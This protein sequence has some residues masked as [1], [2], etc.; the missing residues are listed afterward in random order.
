[1]TQEIRSRVSSSCYLIDF[2]GNLWTFGNNE[3]GQLGHGDD[4][5]NINTPKIINTLI[6]IQQISYGC[7]G[8]HFFAKN[9]QN[10]IFVT[11]NNRYGQLGTGDKESV[12]ILQE[13]NSQYSTI[14]RDEFYTRAKSARK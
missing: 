7:C 6:D 13:I 11:G 14:W 3:K 5:K 2:D 12:S 9:S 10:Q 4:W 8:E 1:M